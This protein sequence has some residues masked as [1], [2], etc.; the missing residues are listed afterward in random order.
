V[1][2]V[3]IKDKVIVI[4]GASS[5]IGAATAVECARAGMKVVANARRADR[6][7]AM[8]EQVR[9]A[10][11]EI[12][13]VVGDVAQAGMSARLLDA[14]QHRFGG[15]YAVFANAGYGF[16]APVHETADERLRHIFEVNFFAASDLLNA[17]VARLLEQKRGGHLIMC[18]S[19]LAK[20]TLPGHGAYSAAKA[21]QNHLCRAMN[22]ELEPRG[23]RVSSVHPITTTTEFFQVSGT[24]SG[25][26]VAGDGVPS[27]TPRFFVQPPERVAR[28]VV[29][30]LR[31]PRPEVWTSVT[32]RAAA[33][34]MTLFP[35]FMDA[36]MRRAGQADEK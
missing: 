28:A 24:L 15:F 14:A 33:A 36:V 18:S 35:W 27:H 17:A 5:G 9:A 8:A 22:I 4:T 2:T 6:L 3:A 7:D 19:C 31:H 25:R 26:E 1:S 30:C 34:A 12:E 16:D 21:A 29:R 10:G 32:T 23:I 13:T 20:F 11:G